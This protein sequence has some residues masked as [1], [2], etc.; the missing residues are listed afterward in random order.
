MG[1]LAKH[2]KITIEWR[3]ES[4]IMAFGIYRRS[5]YKCYDG[6]ESKRGKIVHIYN[7]VTLDSII[8]R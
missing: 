4:L 3:R 6:D 5:Q 7:M 2:S 8:P 1:G